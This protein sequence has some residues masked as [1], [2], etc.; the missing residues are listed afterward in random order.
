MTTN[1][2]IINEEESD[3]EK[4]INLSPTVLKKPQRPPQLQKIP[5]DLVIV[6][7]E[8]PSIP[9]STDVDRKV[10]NRVFSQTFLLY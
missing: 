6:D 10:S 3:L 4:G 2:L 7:P 9:L 5:E 8:V 1:R